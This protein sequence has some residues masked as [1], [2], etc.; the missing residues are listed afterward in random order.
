M[1]REFE[2]SPC[3]AA[4][5]CLKAVERDVRNNPMWT[6]AG[7]AKALCNDLG[8]SMPT[9]YRYVRTAIDVLGI[10]YERADHRPWFRKS[11]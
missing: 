5:R 9:A 11:A 6:M 8:L 10:H 2:M 7:T 1:S 4:M 3:E